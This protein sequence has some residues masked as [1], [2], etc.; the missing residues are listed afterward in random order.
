[1]KD[2]TLRHALAVSMRP[3]EVGEDRTMADTEFDAYSCGWWVR[4]N[5]VCAIGSQG[6]RLVVGSD[7]TLCKLH[8]TGIQIGEFDWLTAPEKPSSWSSK[9]SVAKDPARMCLFD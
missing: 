8:A 2:G 9:W 1:M 3:F 4:G 6:Q 5:N 7:G